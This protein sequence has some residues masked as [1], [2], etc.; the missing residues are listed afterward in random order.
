MVLSCSNPTV[1]QP[2][3]LCV[4][5]ASLAS[6]GIGATGRGRAYPFLSLF[7]GVN[8]FAWIYANGSTGGSQCQGKEKGLFSEVR[9]GEETYHHTSSVL[10]FGSDALLGVGLWAGDAPGPLMTFG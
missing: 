9:V 7:S 4:G 8:C 1:V 6:K 3:R 5:R 10:K 2:G